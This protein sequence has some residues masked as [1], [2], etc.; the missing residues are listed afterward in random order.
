L[1]S[2][3]VTGE[4]WPVLDT[5]HFLKKVLPLRAD[6]GSPEKQGKIVRG[7]EFNT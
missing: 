6:L 2:A 5:E 3:K 7:Q 4:H 1:L